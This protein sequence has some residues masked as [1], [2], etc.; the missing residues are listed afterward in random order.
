MPV[1]ES[2]MSL[3]GTVEIVFDFL[4]R[5]ANLQRI[6]PPSVQ[7]AFVDPPE[8][9]T[10]GSRLVFKIQVFGQVQQFEHEVVEFDRPNR[11]REK[12]IATPMKSWIQDHILEPGES[13][14]VVLHSR[15]EFEPPGGML[16]YILTPD[17]IIANLQEGHEH[18]KEAL[19][20]A[21]Q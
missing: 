14:L 10:L 20:K 3:P 13:G 9:I 11:I 6:S 8:V 19:Q 18:R 21:L 4:S 15:I 5:P 12:A 1:Y 2:Q 17:R 16:G 7:M